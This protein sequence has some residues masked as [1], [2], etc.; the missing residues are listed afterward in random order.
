MEPPVD[1][2]PS[3]WETHGVLNDG[4]T[5]EIRP[6]KPEDRDALDAFH[7][8]QS[9]ESIYFR[10]FRHRPE[11]TDRE[12]DYFTQVDYRK[13]MAFVVMEA[14][15]LVA[16]ALYETLRDKPGQAEVAF[17]VDDAN[18]GRGVGTL[19]LEYLAA[20][21]RDAGFRSLSASVLPENY[22]MLAVFRKA[23][24]DT[25]TRFVD[26]LIEVDIDLDVTP[27]A[28]SIMA[29]RHRRS[30]AQ[31]VA[32]L[33]EPRT[34]AVIGA[35]RRPG[36]IGHELVRS[37]KGDVDPRLTYRGR[38]LA[39]NPKAVGSE[40]LVAGVPAFASVEEAAAALDDGQALDLAI[41]AVPA[42][43]VPEAVTDCGRADVGGL[44][45]ISSGFG[46]FD[47]GGLARSRRLVDQTRDLGMRL[48]GP[49]A[50]G[51]ANTAETVSLNALALP[52]SVPIGSVALAAESGP[53][54]AAVI[55]Q[56]D[57]AGAGLF[58]VAGLGRQIDI[59]IRDLL[60]YW[61]TVEEVA[62]IVVYAENLGDPKALAT[63]ARHV[64]LTKPIVSVA[65][66][67]PALARLLSEA[68]VILV[69]A[70]SQLAAQAAL[71]ST[72]PVPAGPRVAIV[73][74]TSSLARLTRAACH[75]E[76]LEVVVPDSAAAV[77]RDESILVGD[78]DTVSVSRQITS[79]DYENLIVATGVDE[80]VDAIILALAPTGNLPVEEL[81]AVADRVNRSV[82]KPFAVVGLVDPA[83]A[84]AELIPESPS[85]PYFTFPEEAAYV[86]GRYVRYGQWRAEAVIEAE[87][88]HPVDAD[89]TFEHLLGD[90]DRLSITLADSRLPSV[91]D[92]LG[93][94]VAPYGLGRTV[95][96]LVHQAE[97]I[98]Y[99]VVIKLPILVNR[100]VGESGGTAIDVHN[101]HDLRAAYERMSERWPEAAEPV[102]VQRMV[103]YDSMVR[104]ELRAV[105]AFGF[106]LSV[107]YGG[108]AM[109]S[110]DALQ[111]G[112]V[113]VANSRVDSMVDRLVSTIGPGAAPDV[114]YADL[115]A[116][117]TSLADAALETSSLE[118]VTLNPI[119]LSPDGA[120]PVDA[121]VVLAAAPT[122]PLAY[123][124]HL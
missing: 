112:F 56:L 89:A 103:D 61:A 79:R 71:L 57:L 124:R 19:M 47:P 81:E 51:V 32:R 8:R 78:L 14:N 25:K 83:G 44:V 36:S 72:Q 60:I 118:R 35:S 63:A 116:I 114:V 110:T 90:Q 86:L 33:L 11:L 1:A 73:S 22:R 12:L 3:Q 101:A 120:V 7:R 64:S 108:S 84:G 53:L 113:P 46:A 9:E 74:N 111:R 2:Y 69:D 92:A 76:G 91:L 26:G 23:G 55:N 4:G 59:T 20:A 122:T 94:T 6:I 30:L 58:Q 87:D 62:A 98:G 50:F 13:R 96:E 10:F 117:L 115:H 18:H 66:A 5:V 28:S 106:E 16:V 45:V 43:V 75:R 24:L 37:L 77:V 27:S 41:V 65:P 105:E 119:L 109:R 102:V 97:T 67:D 82:D 100:S 42:E 121:E 48:M 104:I 54:A 34:V 21:A 40:Q 70:V 93:L 85:L 52:G 17:F 88:A 49:S 95:D 107:G 15:H 123:V 68:G 38:I 39:I 31:S 99:P 29:S 80:H